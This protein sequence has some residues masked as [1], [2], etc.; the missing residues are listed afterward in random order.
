MKFLK[1]TSKPISHQRVIATS[2]LV[3]IS[4]VVLNVII[5]ILSGSILIVSQ[6]L[7]GA[8]DLCASG[9]LFIGTK[10]SNRKADTTHPFGYG[11]ELYFWVFL[12]GLIMIGVTSTTSFY[13]GLQRVLHPQPIH[14][15]PLAYGVLIISLFTNFYAFSLSFKRLIADKLKVSPIKIF[16]HSPLIATKTTLL[17]DLMGTLASF[18]GIIT[19]I[20]FSLTGNTQYDGIGAMAVGISLAFFSF[21]ILLDVRKLLIGASADPD[22]IDAISNSIQSFSQVVSV[23]DLNVTHIGVEQL[24]VLAKVNLINELTT[25]DIELIIDKIKDKIQTDQPDAKYINIEPETPH[26]I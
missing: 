22:I 6:A 14:N 9:F 2:L 15:V 1:K 19:L 16:F 21:F 18:I 5:A 13:W 24:F 4:D 7:Q 23:V 26:Q 11:R 17:L 25:D 20:M 12:A 3:D 10:R 8:V